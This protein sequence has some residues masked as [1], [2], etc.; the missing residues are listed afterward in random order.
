MPLVSFH[1]KKKSPGRV[2]D[3]RAKLFR[4][5]NLFFVKHYA[6]FV[7]LQNEPELV[8]IMRNSGK[9]EGMHYVPAIAA[10]ATSEH[11]LKKHAQQSC[12]PLLLLWDANGQ[13][14]N[15]VFCKK[16]TGNPQ[17]K[18]AIPTQNRQCASFLFYVRVS[19][20]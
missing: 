17:A 9:L 7:K 15:Q 4:K 6:A 18:A 5:Q 12:Q 2:I 19:K 16:C 14:I 8:N 10:A 3:W 13:E 11:N 1:Q 20:H